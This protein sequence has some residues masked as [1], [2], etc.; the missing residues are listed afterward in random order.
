[1]KYTLEKQLRTPDG[2]IKLSPLCS[3][4]ALKHFFQDAGGAVVHHPQKQFVVQRQFGSLASPARRDL[5][6]CRENQHVVGPSLA[7]LAPVEAMR[8]FGSWKTN[9]VVAGVH[10]FRKQAEAVFFLRR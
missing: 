7:R 6:S 3:P 4:K 5:W 2:L 8:H 10:P 9:M 1:M